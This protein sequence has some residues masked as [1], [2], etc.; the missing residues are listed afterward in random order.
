METRGDMQ[1]V[2]AGVPLAELFGYSTVIRSLTRGRATYTME[3]EEF[4][5]VP[6]G[7]KQELLSK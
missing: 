4:A 3:P 1:I 7:I 5:I 6:E 2:Q